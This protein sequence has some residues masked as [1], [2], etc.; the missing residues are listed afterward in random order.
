M[1]FQALSDVKYASASKKVLSLCH[2]S[3]QFCV[4]FLDYSRMRPPPVSD[5]FTPRVVGY[6]RVACIID[7]LVAW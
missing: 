2:S 3:I 6:E 4:Y 5:H 1:I 7:E